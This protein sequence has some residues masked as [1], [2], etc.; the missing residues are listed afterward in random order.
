MFVMCKPPGD[1][2]QAG[3]QVRESIMGLRV[4]LSGVAFPHKFIN[5]FI[6]K[7]KNVKEKQ[8]NYGGRRVSVFS[9]LTEVI[10]NL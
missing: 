7:K 1:L 2:S 5:T 3:A 8:R 9:S 6:K 4:S 10:F